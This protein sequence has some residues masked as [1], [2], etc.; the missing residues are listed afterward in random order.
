ML[1]LNRFLTTALLAIAALTLSAASAAAAG[2]SGA[3]VFSRVTTDSSVTETATGEKI[4]KDPEGGLYAARDGRFNR[5]TEDPADQEPA[6]SR[7]GHSIAFIREG[8]LYTMRA[9]GSGSVP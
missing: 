4:K 3:L 1:K 9:D 2:S 7:D 5:L 6:F 8:D